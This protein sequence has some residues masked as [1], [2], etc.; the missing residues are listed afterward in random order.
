M[1][2]ALAL[3]AL[4][5]GLAG[6]PHCMAMCGAPCAAITAPRQGEGPARMWAFHLFRTMGYALAGAVAA[7]SVGVLA[8]LAAWAPTVRPLW[9]LLH[10]AAFGLGLWLLW[11]GRQPSW[12]ESLGRPIAKHEQ[13]PGGWQ[14]LRGPTQAGAAGAMWV[15]WPC[16]LLQSALMVAALANSGL[17]GAGIMAGFAIVSGLGLALGPA[18]WLRWGRQGVNNVTAS[19][20]G[21]RFAGAT[22][23]AASLWAL[24]HDLLVRFAAYCL[25]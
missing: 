16:G 3:S 7:S 21:V 19:L 13:L 1:D 22:L 15:A 10:V 9:T 23:A 6:V 5:L 17:A 2:V 24:G 8:S 20:W 18:L 25:S 11:S 14:R 4:M 12:L